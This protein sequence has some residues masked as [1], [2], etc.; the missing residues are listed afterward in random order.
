MEVDTG[1][2]VLILDQARAQDVGVDLAGPDT[3]R[4]KGR[5]ETG[6]PFTRYFATIQGSISV[7]G[8]PAIGQADPEVMFQ[9][10]IYD[11]LVGT[12]FLRNFAVTYDLPGS[13]MI[14][15]PAGLPG[16]PQADGAT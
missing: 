4:V 3:R 12:A 6:Q 8:A 2:D 5:D 1:S 15:G 7:T 11:G 14:F 13:R 9:K 16:E 10:I